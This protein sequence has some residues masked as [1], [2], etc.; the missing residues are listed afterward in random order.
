MKLARGRPP[1]TAIRAAAEVIAG[2]A[3]PNVFAKFDRRMAASVL[4]SYGEDTLSE[5]VLLLPDDEFELV[6]R[7]ATTLDD[8]SYP[9][10]VEGQRITNGHVI[11]FAVVTCFEGLRPLARN[12]RR[13]A[14]DRPPHLA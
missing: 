14:K 3:P 2:Q 11:A 8:P 7:V 10:P 12:R 5:Q 9:L 6:Q 1:G 13:A 4:W